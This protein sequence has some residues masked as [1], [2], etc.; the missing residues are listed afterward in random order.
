MKTKLE[1]MLEELFFVFQVLVML[2]VGSCILM[3]FI[4]AFSGLFE[5]IF[6]I[7]LI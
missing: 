1:V 2:L 4:L 7:K 6:K 5:C 3:A